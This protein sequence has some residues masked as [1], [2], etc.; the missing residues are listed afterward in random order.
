M[1]FESSVAFNSYAKGLLQPLFYLVGVE[2]K[3]D[4]EKSSLPNYVNT[5][6]TD[7]DH[8]VDKISVGALGRWKALV[9]RSVLD[10]ESATPAGCGWPRLLLS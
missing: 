3:Q 7:V 6:G 9:W 2:T 4:S 10:L 5:A 8:G 1:S